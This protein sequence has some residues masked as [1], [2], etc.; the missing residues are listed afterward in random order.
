MN[1]WEHWRGE[2]GDQGKSY[3]FMLST[4]GMHLYL[5]KLGKIS[6]T[7]ACALKTNE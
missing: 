1:K 3:K 4:Q 6:P 5:V 7:L 2:H